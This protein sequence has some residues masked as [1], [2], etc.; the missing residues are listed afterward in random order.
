MSKLK[1]GDCLEN[2]VMTDI[3]EGGKALGK[4][5][6]MVVFVKGAIP[7]DEADV[8]ITKVKRRYA[9]AEVLS[10]I[11][12]SDFRTEPMCKH[13]G[14]C[15]GCKWQHMAYTEQLR[16]KQK[17]VED[18]LVR[19]GKV[20]INEI[21]NIIPSEELYNYRNKLE[22]TFSHKRW[23]TSEEMKSEDNNML[24]MNALGFH[25]PGMF[26]KVLPID[27]CYLQKEPSNAIRLA[28]RDFTLKHEYPY[29]DLKEQV[30]LMRNLII[31]NSNTGGLMVIVVFHYRD[32]EK[33]IALLDHLLEQ[34][35][36]IT[37][38]MYVINEKRNDT[39]GDLD[40]VLYKGDDFLTEQME[41]LSF[42]IGPKS[43][44]QTNS[45][46][47]LTL[48]RIVREFAALKGTEVVY[49]LYTGTGT[50][51]MFLAQNAAKVVGVEYVEQAVENARANSI[52]N[53]LN[54][55]VFEAGIMEKILND[56]F[57]EKHGR[58]DVVITDPP[59]SGM[60]PAV[61]EQLLQM[62]APRIVYVSCNPATQARDLALLSA[63]YEVIKIQ[64]VD[65]FPH[66]EHVENVALLQIIEPN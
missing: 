41:N 38:L 59:R 7:G 6:G 43:F 58:P 44:F 18:N 48:Y 13:F 19:I 55:T 9:E 65:M 46:Q 27:T 56:T 34:F 66:T 1:W 54:N 14:V 3:A 16:F 25:I 52:L 31:R 10:F 62:A 11:K 8:R 5:A 50:I 15:G 33:I 30:G 42:R 35:P 12:Q 36:E 39:I 17:Q 22:Y 49:D 61:V 28:V 23:L 24:N 29:F 40:V 2:V 60:H 21:L 64:P 4:T 20:K 45:L 51:A 63:K 47:A 57:I 37:S 32:D 53:H 26:S